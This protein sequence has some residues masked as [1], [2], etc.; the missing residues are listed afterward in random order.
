VRARL[1]AFPGHSDT[2]EYKVDCP[3]STVQATEGNPPARQGAARTFSIPPVA[4]VA[5][6][7]VTATLKYR[8]V[9]Q[10]LV[11]FLFGHDSSITAP[12]VDIVRATANIELIEPGGDSG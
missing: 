1:G 5:R 6:L 9:D 2:V 7:H 11:N 4:R 10:F 12:V 8:K 3:G